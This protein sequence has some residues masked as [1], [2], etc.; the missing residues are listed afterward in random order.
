MKYA[1]DLSFSF[2]MACNSKSFYLVRDAMLSSTCN[3]KQVLT[4]DFKK[5]TLL[6][7]KF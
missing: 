1:Y 2:E 7:S 4:L 3:I 6:K 5:V